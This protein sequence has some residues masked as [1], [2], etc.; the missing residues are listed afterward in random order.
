M[1]KAI[2]AKKGMYLILDEHP[3]YITEVK[4][5]EGYLS[6]V[7]ITGLDVL[8]RKKYTELC[9]PNTQLTIF[10][11]HKQTYILVDVHDQFIEIQDDTGKV[12]IFNIDEHICTLLSKDFNINI[13]IEVTITRAPYEGMCASALTSWQFL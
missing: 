4:L 11:P 8:T 12:S 10:T 6:R 2:S 1:Q 9:D 3:C 5:R 13:N 7:Y